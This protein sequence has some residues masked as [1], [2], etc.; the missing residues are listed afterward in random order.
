MPTN[1][2]NIRSTG[3]QINHEDALRRLLGDWEF[4]TEPEIKDGKIVIEGGDAQSFMANREDGEIRTHQ[5]LELLSEYLETTLVIYE[6]K[7]RPNQEVNEWE[8]KPSK[9][10]PNTSVVQTH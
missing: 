10:T 7:V 5:F 3:G 8:I 2:Y 6:E 4:T 9:D 1:V